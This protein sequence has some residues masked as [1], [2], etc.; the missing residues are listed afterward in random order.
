MSANRMS[1]LSMPRMPSSP[2]WACCQ[3]RGPP[4]ANA[5]HLMTPTKALVSVSIDKE[6]VGLLRTLPPGG[7]P[8]ASLVS[9]GILVLLFLDCSPYMVTCHKRTQ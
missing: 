8:A 9:A 6:G 4:Q 2:R 5:R 3:A 1:S 7:V